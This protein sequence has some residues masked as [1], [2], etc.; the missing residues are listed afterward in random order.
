[1]QRILVI[2]DEHRI[3]TMLVKGLRRAGFDTIAVPDGASGIARATSGEQLHLIL[4]DLGLPDIDGLVVM[5][6]I[7]ALGIDT[8]VV[9]LSAREAMEDKVTALANGAGDYVS[10]PFTFDDLVKRIRCRLAA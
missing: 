2:E 7:R 8:P 5:G 6:R 10:K 4:L 9:V 1:M 3:R